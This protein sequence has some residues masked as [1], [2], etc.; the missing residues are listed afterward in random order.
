METISGIM[1]FIQGRAY[2]EVS[3]VEVQMSLGDRLGLLGAIL[4]LVAIAAPYLWPD[5]KWI[6]WA[7]L[8]CAAALLIAWAWIEFGSELPRLRAN[9]PI[10]SAVAAFAVGGCLALALWLLIQPSAKSVDNGDNV[11]RIEG[12][13]KAV[14]DSTYR[15]LVASVIYAFDPRATL[16]VGDLVG[17]PDGPRTVDIEVRSLSEDG[18]P[19]LIAIDVIDLPSGRK[20]DIAAVDA[21]DSKRADIKASVMLVCSNTGFDEI[22]IRKAKR[23]QIGLISIL[24]QGDERVKAV[25]N[26]QIYLRKVNVNPLTFTFTGMTMKDRGILERSSGSHALQYGGKFVDAWLM[27]KVA[28]IVGYNP[29]LDKRVTATFNLKNGTKFDVPSGRPKLRAL[30]V[31]FQPHTQWLSQ[32]VQ[33]DAT[34]GIYDYLRSRVRLAAGG[35]NSYVISGINFDTAVPLSSPPEL[36]MLGFGLKPGEVEARLMMIE[37]LDPTGAADLDSLIRP[38]DLDLK[39]PAIP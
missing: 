28:I 38:E 4:A 29:T 32:T 20:A 9:Y 23:K 33:L 31:S 27:E 24:R 3:P 11:S 15:Q 30:A 8:S 22:A 26:E 7:A 21:A 13:L 37:G 35:N 5:K 34:T 10:R 6:G 14:P 25:I 36:D 12:L 16:S 39:V 17:T 19:L 18:K 1:H 2:H